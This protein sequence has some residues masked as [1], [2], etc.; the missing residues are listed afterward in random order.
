[1]KHC[2]SFKPL[3][4]YYLKEDEL[5]TKQQL[6]VGFCPLCDKPVAELYSVRFDGKIEKISKAGI[7]ANEILTKYKDKILYSM[8]ECNYSR[9]MSR[10]FGWKYGINKNVKING[11]EHIKQYSSDFYGNTELIKVI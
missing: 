11:K 9:F 10:P 7:K 2:C 4:V 6:S 3:D 5:H 1:M 8:Q